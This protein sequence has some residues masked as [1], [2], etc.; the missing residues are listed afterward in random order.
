MDESIGAVFM[1]HEEC[2]KRTHELEALIDGAIDEGMTEEA[3]RI[4]LRHVQRMLYTYF[5]QITEMLKTP[6]PEKKPPLIPQPLRVAKSRWMGKHM[7]GHEAVKTDVARASRDL[8]PD[9]SR[10][11]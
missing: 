10:L 9:I 5:D 6:L 7:D 2:Y 4:N 8:Y 11:I 1:K 3:A